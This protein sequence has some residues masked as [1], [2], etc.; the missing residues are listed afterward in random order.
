[1]P[2]PDW[3]TF[4]GVAGV[5]T[6]LL[7]L[8]ARAS[9]G[10]VTGGSARDAAGAVPGRSRE[11]PDGHGDAG[12][13]TRTTT[14]G[15]ANAGGEGGSTA[16]GVPSAPARRPAS[17]SST[18]EEPSAATEA[19]PD[20]APGDGRDREGDRDGAGHGSSHRD[21]TGEVGD[22]TD[23]GG[24]D[25]EGRR[26]VPGTGGVD[27]EPES[28]EP[29][30]RDE[31]RHPNRDALANGEA[32]PGEPST[33]GREPGH[34]YG[35]PDLDDPATRGVGDAPDPGDAADRPGAADA[36]DRPGVRAGPST[37]GGTDRSAAPT[38]HEEGR[39]ADPARSPGDRVDVGDDGSVPRGVRQLQEPELD[40]S[41]GALLANVAISQGLF[42]ALLIAA[43]WWTGVP[44]SA[45]G[46][47]PVDPTALAAGAA[48][49]VG[50]Y[51]ANEV[52]AAVGERFGIPGGEALREALA[53]ETAGGWV[54]LLLVVLPIIAGFEELLFRGVLIGALSAG[55]GVSPWLLAAV[56]SVAFALGHGAQGRLGIVVTGL[57]GFVL[58]AGFVL[59]GSLF[60]VVLAHY[61]VNAL[62]FVVHEGLGVDW[63]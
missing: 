33:P 57:L 25:A 41:A 42:A 23:P 22:E 24:V 53:P 40:L 35:A 12:D 1:M 37:P 61:L 59:T 20:E 52:G 3:S 36:A 28:V 55:F 6:V 26:T 8:L 34:R 56:S 50:L 58:A 19:G 54:V 38:R 17:G 13:D 5:L 45:F 32:P 14:T 62:E 11:R 43:A 18:D 27:R 31:W 48:L 2:T 16:T 44:A 46:V 60:A 10:A 39:D 47:G 29:V 21:G 30:G 51:V 9:Q 63:R 4:A 15:S 49:G 7:L